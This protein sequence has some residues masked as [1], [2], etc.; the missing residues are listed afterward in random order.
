[1]SHIKDFQ[2]TLD[3]VEA[4]KTVRGFLDES[5][6]WRDLQDVEIIAKF[7]HHAEAMLS[8]D[9]FVKTF[10][11]WIGLGIIK[12]FASDKKWW[13]ITRI[14]QQ[15][16]PR[17]VIPR[18]DGLAHRSSF[19]SLSRQSSL[20]ETPA[21]SFQKKPNKTTSTLRP[22]LNTQSPATPTDRL[23]N[24]RQ[25]SNDM[26]G[27]V[28]YAE[29]ED[30]DVPSSSSSNGE[31]EESREKFPQ[32][33]KTEDANGGHIIKKLRLNR[34]KQDTA[35]DNPSQLHWGRGRPPITTVKVLPII[36]LLTL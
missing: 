29:V 6:N 2:K 25:L 5:D 13:K 11:D 32:K 14:S 4:A 1:M 18:K 12:K 9:D 3:L 28:R 24:T 27:I 30:I 15:P 36:G 22:I 10:E 31:Q 19:A 21:G 20:M 23:S 26:N 7:D 8:N 17:E 35:H 34:S 33:R 16:D